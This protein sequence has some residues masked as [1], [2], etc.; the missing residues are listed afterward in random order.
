MCLPPNATH[1][2]QP[3][4]VAVFGPLKS[5]WQDVLSDF[6]LK[7]P[8]HTSL[9]KMHFPGL[10]KTLLDEA[11][12]GQNMAAGF[13]KCGLFPVSKEA[14]I[15]RLPRRNSEDASL[16]RRLLD[17]TF[18]ERLAELRGVDGKDKEKKKRGKKVPPGQSYCDEEEDDAME[19]EVMEDE[20]MEDEVREDRDMSGQ[21]SDSSD[22]SIRPI[23]MRQRGSLEDSDPDEPQPRRTE[24]DQNFAVGS[25]VIAMYEGTWYLGQVEG[26]DP[27]DEIDGYTCV[28]YME[29]KGVNKF[30]FNHKDVLPT[31]N[32]DILLT[33]DH[34]VPVSNR[35]FWGLPDEMLCTVGKL[36]KGNWSI[37][38][39]RI[40]KLFCKVKV[41]CIFVSVW[42]R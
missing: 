25:F 16:I 23:R 2:I 36:V 34:P 31:L 11:K 21:E 29:K 13:R 1:L 39:K 42:V 5:V 14:V 28:K 7:H 6:K 24:P 19:D 26:Q 22:V 33:V 37:F 12:P 40:L 4:D 10:L 15:C 20:V 35:G 9:L 8:G 38:Y 17:E 41:K 30:L 27:E 18:S 32:T 3:L